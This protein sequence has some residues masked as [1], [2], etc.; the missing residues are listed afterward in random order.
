MHQI[1]TK[2]NETHFWRASKILC[3]P[4]PQEKGAVTSPETEPDFLVTVQESPAEAWVESVLPCHGVGSP[5]ISPFEGGHHY[6]HHRYYSLASDQTTGREHSPV[7]QQKIAL[8]IYL[9]W[10]HPSEQDPD[11]LTASPFYQEVSTSLLSLFVRGQ[12]EWKPQSQ[13]TNQTDH[14]D[15]SLV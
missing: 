5:G 8:K 2:Y 15:Y 4:G 1:Y 14:L 9:A 12:T 10:S 6:S 7:H 3:A 13:K 11:T